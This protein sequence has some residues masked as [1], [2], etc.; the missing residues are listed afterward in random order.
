MQTSQS[1]LIFT[2]KTRQSLTAYNIAT[3]SR[4]RIITQRD[5]WRLVDWFQC[6]KLSQHASRQ[7]LVD[8]IID[9]FYL[10]MG[11]IGHRTDNGYFVHLQISYVVQEARPGMF[12]S[13]ALIN[14]S[15]DS[16][17]DDILWTIL[18]FILSSGNICNLIEFLIKFTFIH[19][20]Q[21]A[22]SNN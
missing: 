5:K 3:K 8:I 1:R 6:V 10:S 12:F 4:V 19:T 9:Q 17:M 22:G 16:K 11:L 15:L 20:V 21:M 18:S 14:G 13:L 2:T 7:L